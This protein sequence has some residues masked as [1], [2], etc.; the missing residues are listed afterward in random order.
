MR[1][2]ND[3][4]VI[5]SR[6]IIRQKWHVDKRNVCVGDVVMIQDSNS[7]RGQWKVGRVYRKP[8]LKTME[9]YAGSKCGTSVCQRKRQMYTKA[10]LYDNRKACAKIGCNCCGK[11]II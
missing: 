8:W 10:S 6:A 2:G 1:S 11:R 3:G 5:I 4:S 9:E 7:V